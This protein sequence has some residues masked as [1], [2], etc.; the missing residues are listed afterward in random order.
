M[1]C[2][3]DSPLPPLHCHGNQETV[4]CLVEVQGYY[5]VSHEQSDVKD[6]QHYSPVKHHDL[7]CR[8]SDG[9]ERCGDSDCARHTDHHDNKHGVALEE[10]PE[11]R[12]GRAEG[13]V[14]EQHGTAVLQEGGYNRAGQRA[15]QRVH[16]AVHRVQVVR[17]VMRAA[18]PEVQ[19]CGDVAQD[20]KN[21][22]E[23]KTS[24]DCSVSGCTVEVSVLSFSRV[25]HVS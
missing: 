2:H 8:F 4:H 16:H 18:T 25:K 21:Q 12:V 20:S 11:E 10:G 14:S 5:P 22:E 23:D 1:K 3:E 17:K 24:S 15:D 7:H 19:G 9:V 13:A 6:S